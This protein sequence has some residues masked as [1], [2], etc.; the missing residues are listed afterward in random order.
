[1]AGALIT[2]PAFAGLTYQSIG[3]GGAMLA[4]ALLTTAPE[5]PGRRVK[6]HA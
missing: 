1:M 2:V 6:A 5:P 4:G 3:D